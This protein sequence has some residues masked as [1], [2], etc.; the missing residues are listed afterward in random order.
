MREVLAL[1]LVTLAPGI[2]RGQSDVV[3]DGPEH[4]NQ[5][6]SIGESLQ[7][8]G[9]RPLHILYVHGIGATAA[10][11]SLVFQQ[12]MCKFLKHCTAET[13]RR[14]KELQSTKFHPAPAPRDYA[15]GGIFEKGA[16][17]PAFDYMGHK[18]WENA[19]E[20]SASAPFVDHYV[21]WR[22]D[23]G[24]I[25]VDEINWWPLVL[26][27][28]CRHIMAG[29]ARLA[30]PYKRIL[31]VCS[32]SEVQDEANPGRFRAY[33]WVT[34]QEAKEWGSIPA[35]G[36]L[37]NRSLKNVILDWGFSDAVMAVGVM[38]GVFREGMRQLF[39]QSARFN[40]DGS[41]TNDWAKELKEPHGMDREFI[42][43]S[44]SLG[45]YLVFSTMNM[46]QQ[47][48]ALS[49][50]IPEGTPSA[51]ARGK[52]TED[53]AAKYIFERTSLVYFFANQIPLLELAT[54]E[55]PVE[56]GA[57]QAVEKGKNEAT[58]TLSA[59]MKKWNTLRRSFGKTPSGEEEPA[60]R[61]RQVV[62]WS[63][64]SDLLTWRIPE[65]KGLIVD[66]LYV[67]NT[68][69]RWIV[70]RPIAAHVNYDRNRAVIHVMMSP[71][72]ESGE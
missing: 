64:P 32:E 20:W 58:A 46:E 22:T 55:T 40:A 57:V 38:H 68:F 5:I 37:F 19:D 60:T 25:V 28:K 56:A 61:P 26:P 70:A 2:A 67:R 24:P 17:P 35:K 43:V 34:E 52:A 62:A 44:H 39:L 11:D 71:K 3:D 21:L 49:E 23:G 30:G 59:E 13:L 27:L 69:W 7:T 18:V 14:L 6:S 15:A 45:S 72:K 65:M 8:A 41:R 31:K 16:A 66:N 51:S 47:E 50:N 54:M 42:V 1:V 36:A 33:P 12:S 29:E 10:G 48:E 53:A 4:L 9:Q 63:D